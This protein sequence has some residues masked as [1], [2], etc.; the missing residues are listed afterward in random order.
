MLEIVSEA[1]SDAAKRYYFLHPSPM[2]VRDPA[3]LIRWGV[4]VLLLPRSF[5]ASESAGQTKPFTKFNF[6]GN[7]FSKWRDKIGKRRKL[8]NCCIGSF[9]DNSLVVN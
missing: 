7:V 4:K 8:C 1:A 9:L 2:E 3:P 5:F 6:Y